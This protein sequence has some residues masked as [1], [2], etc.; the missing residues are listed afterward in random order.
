MPHTMLPKSTMCRQVV[1]ET[2]I[3]PGTAGSQHKAHGLLSRC[4][5]NGHKV[6]KSLA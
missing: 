2:G 1:I 6:E 5:T 3:T 4:A